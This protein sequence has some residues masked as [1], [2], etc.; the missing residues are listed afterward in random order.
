MRGPTIGLPLS[1]DYSNNTVNWF[2]TP[3]RCMASLLCSAR[4]HY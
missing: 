2:N 3:I 4:H 1:D